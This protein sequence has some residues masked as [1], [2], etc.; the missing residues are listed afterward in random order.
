MYTIPYKARLVYSFKN[1]NATGS[2]DHPFSGWHLVAEYE[3]TSHNT[4]QGLLKEAA[5]SARTML[6]T[7][8]IEV[9]ADKGYES[10]KD[11]LNCVM[12]GIVP[13]VAMKSDKKERT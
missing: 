7:E 2:H 5:D 13:N 10:R 9:G 12:N 1:I 3:V 6:E 8:T 11:I 4:D